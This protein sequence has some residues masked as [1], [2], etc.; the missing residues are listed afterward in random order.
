MILYWKRVLTLLA[1]L[2]FLW[3][4]VPCAAGNDEPAPFP[5]VSARSWAV[6]D[7]IRFLTAGGDGQVLPMAST[8]KIMTALIVCEEYDLS[9]IVEIT[10]DCYA[11]GSSMYLRAGER[12]TVRDLLCGL[13][14]MSGNDAAAALAGLYHGGVD[15]FV[16]RM[17][18][19]AAELGLK[20]TAFVTPSG[21][22]GEG[23]HSTARELAVLAAAA[24]RLDPFR[25]IVSQRSV[26]A[27]G[28]AMQNHNKL[29]TYCPDC[30]GVK[31]GYTKLAGRCLVSA[32]AW[33]GGTL[34]IVT[35][36]A[37]DDWNDHQKLK[38][39]AEENYP[40]VT[41]AAAGDAL[42]SIP[43][44]GGTATN[45]A[46][47]TES[48]VIG[49]LTDAERTQIVMEVYAPHYLYAPVKKGRRCGV[50]RFTLR[51]E[52]IGETA[53]TARDGAERAA[54]KR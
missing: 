9:Q 53:L 12:V 26:T 18:E 41:L 46:L 5:E 31:T 8:T 38:R 34:I 49:R 30:I 13:M 35:L 21:L 4:A 15:G 27:A 36:D 43:V 47:L 6:Y 14:L 1:V 39:W 22:D 11:E 42:C 19:R 44:F 7:G 10:P 52:V 24:M 32:F 23:H 40:P 50:V 20:D 29:L 3:S 17:N 33:E 28:R 48:E 51:G 54:A 37:P 25:E 2:L 16:T 45:I